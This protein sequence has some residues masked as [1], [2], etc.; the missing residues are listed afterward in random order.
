M[1]GVTKDNDPDQDCF[2]R[3]YIITLHQS[4]K[5]Q[6]MNN[7]LAVKGTAHETSNYYR[8]NMGTI[9]APE[10]MKFNKEYKDL[11]K[12]YPGVK[13]SD[14]DFSELKLELN[15][16]IYEYRDEAPTEEVYD[17]YYTVERN[18]VVNRRDYIHGSG[19]PEND[20]WFGR[21]E[22]WLDNSQSDYAAAGITSNKFS[23]WHVDHV[24]TLHDGNM[25]KDAVVLTA[26][27]DAKTYDGTALTNDAFEVSGLPEG[28]KV[29]ATVTG[30]ATNVGDEG[31]NTITSYTILKT[32]TNEDVTKYFV[33]VTK[34]DGKLTINKRSVILTSATD[35]KEY[36][37]IPLTNDTITV[38]GDGF[39]TGEGASYEVTG[40]Q[41]I[42]GSSENTFT[43]TLNE[44]TKEANYNI[45]EK[46][47]TLTVTNRDAKY[48]IEVVANSGTEKY[49][50]KPHEVSGF[51]TTTFKVDGN[52]YT[53][54]GL[55]ASVK[56]TDADTYPVNV[57]GKAVVKDSEGHD[58]TEQFA[59]TTKNGELI[60]TKRTVI[61]TSADAEKVYDTTALTNDTVTVTGDGFVVGEGA[62]YDVTGTQTEVG[63]SKNNF[64]YKLNEGTKAGNYAIT[65]VP[66]T[67]EVTP[68][69]TPIT[70]TI[71]EN[72]GE[73]TY[74]GEEHEVTGYDVT[75][76][77]AGDA[78][79]KLY[80]TADFS[81]G[82]DATV[83]GTDAGDYPMELKATDF[84]NI[85]K[86][87]TDV[88]FVIVDGKLS[89]SK[90]VVT[91][92]SA[93]DEKV[94][95]KTALT[96]ATVTVTGDGFADGEGATYDVT[97]KQTEVGESK[98]DFT[99]T[100][101]EGTK[102]DNYTIETV[103][104]TLKVTPY[105]KPV[106]VTI[107][108]NSGT[109]KYDGKAH[110]VEGYSVDIDDKL[111]ATSDF[112]FSG[113]AKVSG[114]DAGSYAMELKPEDF[115]NNNKNFTNVTFVIVDGEL[116]ISK[117]EVTLTSAD[118][119]KV[120]D[121]TALTND[122][123]TVTGDGFAVGEGATY[124][125][126]G[127]QTEVGES[128]NDFTYTLSEGTKADN[129]TI[130][131]VPGT[132]KVTPYTKPVKV[133]IT[134]NSGTAK[135]DGKAHDVEGYSVDIDDKLY[136]TSDFSF[137]GNAKVSGR[138]AGS[139][140]MELKPE[141]FT[142]NNK[143]FTNVTF[144]IV[145]GE[146][147]ISKR[148][149]MMTS[150]DDEKVY[151]KTALTNSSVT[152][153]GDGFVEGEGA[154]YKVTGTQTIVGSSINTF[155]YELNAGT[156]AENYNITTVEGILTVTP[157]T[158]PVTVTI[159][160][161]SGE[162]SYDGSEHTVTGYDVAISD[163]LY[164]EADFDFSG[165]D[166]VTGINA[167]IYPMELKPE[168]FENTNANF[169]NVT[170]EIVDGALT[171]TPKTITLTV[172]DK[173]KTYGD[174]DPTFTASYGEND[175]VDGDEVPYTFT[176]AEGENAGEYAINATAADPNYT[177]NVVP[178]TLTIEPKAITLTVDDKTKT[179]GDGDPAFTA[180]YGEGDLVDGDEV[181]FTFTREEGEN[182]GEY[183]INATADDPNYTITVVP[184]T[185]TI[186]PKAI[187][188]T[189]DDKTKTYGDDD[190]AFTASY[191]EG[192]LAGEDVVTYTLT[193]E[194]GENAGE[195]TI[196][197]TA[198]DPN[199]TITVEPGTL[200][201]AKKAATVKADEKTK[202]YDNN[203]TT[204]PALT[205]VV[206]GTLEGEEIKYTLSREEGQAVKDYAITVAAGE[207]PNYDVTVE[208]NIFH[209]T[210]LEGVTVTIT[211]H[212]GTYTYN[213]AARTVSGYDVAI[214]NPLYTE[215]DF[216]FNGQAAVT[217]TNAGTY[218]MNLK[219]A[220]FTNNNPNFKDVTFV[221]VPG[222]LVIN[223]KA[224]KITADNNG[225]TYGDKDPVLTATIEGL[226]GNDN[227][228]TRQIREAGENAGSYRIDANVVGQYPNYVIETVP[229]TFTITP[230]QITVTVDD[231]TKAFG[232]EEPDL[233]VTIKGL[234]EGDSEELITYTL[235]REP[236]ETAGTYAIT[237]TGEELQGNYAVTYES[238]EMEIAAENTVVVTIT[239]NKGEYVYD[240][241]EKDLSGYTVKISSEN[242]TEDDFIF[243]GSSEL[244]GVNA[245][246]YY[247]NMKPEDFVNTNENFDRVIFQ[248]NNGELKII[249]RT[250]TLTS[251][252]DS[253]PYDG[254]ALTN[255][256]VTVGGDG[257]APGEGLN[258][259]V[260]GFIIQEGSV[261]NSFDYTMETGTL[262]QNYII[263]T[264]YGKLTITQ[265]VTHTLTITYKD[266]DGNVVRTFKR[267]Y[268]FGET[269]SVTTPSATGYRA[270]ITTVTGTMGDEDIEV[271]VTYKVSTATLTVRYVSITDG[272]E[273]AE[274][275]VMEL[276]K[277]DNYTVFTPV[278]DGYTTLQSEVSGVMPD[279]NRTITVFMVP[280]GTSG[281]GHKHIEIEDYGTPLGVPESILG[282]GEIIE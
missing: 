278:V 87:F 27:S 138:D 39:A 70:V 28:Y 118:D 178:G 11:L 282:G 53:V 206:E 171:I 64:S 56:G 247:T 90:R 190:P 174:G 96:N 66:G 60:I 231:K 156:K 100:L 225:K 252:S 204:D 151:D 223:Q 21:E 48:T 59:V 89:I 158:T 44:G 161:H 196:N 22:G 84:Q 19:K 235:S 106:K 186:E 154:A 265:G 217:G 233:T 140:A 227:I 159:T 135:Y 219:A 34:K 276:K 246:T 92:T 165:T 280:E 208:G 243:N 78:A 192:D 82:G 40:S 137:S 136:A 35:S 25:I 261:D 91:L 108:E 95:D 250:I 200:T 29:E 36:N 228:A 150:A 31:V 263:R 264:T 76:I 180:S 127:K 111:Y 244:K 218:G 240:G 24:A 37:G 41:T 101:S 168:D 211:E 153:T 55:S 236:G 9:T 179:Y 5:E 177:I 65:T 266:E 245:G 268:A 51:V 172:D 38:T 77:L 144:V 270:D 173:T 237:V 238:G 57:I 97:G 275:V 45:S 184:G 52:D 221:I 163:D 114:R 213:A 272:R 210:P 166:E 93:D 81:F 281:E 117:R 214:S 254:T 260:T 198:S 162:A 234:V 273:V 13:I 85:N 191:G 133:T 61:M 120:Y 148:E 107:T 249:K 104:G 175:L 26:A 1:P 215:A 79:T 147:A 167:G 43:Y 72:S 115:T 226:E 4:Y 20:D 15:N 10:G 8:L 164:T 54:T 2:L 30:S 18:K 112:S 152:E 220:N 183:A 143:N 131:T 195:Y 42:A 121:K 12:H 88:T 124:D 207:N 109:A 17:D 193:R 169:S 63:D 130:E 203:P 128:K 267:D 194:E 146:L 6:P 105:T 269:Y 199:Y 126:T 202:V 69:T 58:V 145:D 129:Y 188:L 68:Y 46:L 255:D 253:K 98:N 116:S 279:A 32:D 259:T 209:I 123:V 49:D 7:F 248:I 229:G 181:S 99:Y 182:A 258:L 239:A 176:R 110:D 47:G 102:A 3:K 271:T 71:T 232:E 119:E 230:K 274:P 62:T 160:E 262:E 257:F 83:V 23:S 113:N 277:N 157:Y 94:Y 16:K 142:N 33:N 103:P 149:V 125:V 251:A 197:A 212:S 132:L 139:Y 256:K 170:F 187:T 141:D 14:Y 86:N 241:Q 242:Y 134:E 73:E 50:G 189:V 205:A 122:T 74:D 75:S 224:V 185:L 201:I 155:S 216:T 222:S 80:T 67:L